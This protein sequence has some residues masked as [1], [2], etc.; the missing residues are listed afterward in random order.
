MFT[1]VN[2]NRPLEN[3]DVRVYV[4]RPSVLGNPF[5]LGKDGDRQEVIA[6]YRRWLWEEIKKR[7]R[8]YKELVGLVEFERH[9]SDI[10]LACHCYPQAC[11]ADILVKALEW[12][13][14]QV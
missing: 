5:K 3:N 7:E 1:V 11:H 13:K 8:V 2:V 9:A 10:Q 12:L 6:K 4:G 14:T